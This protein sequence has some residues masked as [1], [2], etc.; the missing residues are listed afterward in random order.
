MD[1]IG[2]NAEFVTIQVPDA[3]ITPD[4]NWMLIPKQWVSIPFRWDSNW[5]MPDPLK[6]IVGEKEFQIRYLDG[7]LT[8][9]VGTIKQVRGS[10]IDIEP[11]KVVTTRFSTAKLRKQLRDPH[12]SAEVRGKTYAWLLYRRHRGWGL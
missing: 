2:E 10:S 8:E 9:F 12:I 4:P 1:V 11:S 6:Y 3:D 7:N 5:T